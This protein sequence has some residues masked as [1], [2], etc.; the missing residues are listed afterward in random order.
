MSISKRILLSV[1]FLLCATAAYAATHYVSPTGTAEWA[2]STDIAQPSAWSTAMANAVAGDIVYFRGGTYDPGT[3]HVPDYEY[4]SMNP[5]N[6][7]TAGNTITF[8]AYP[9][10]TPTITGNNSGTAFGAG[11][12]DYIVW[13]GFTAT[14]ASSASVL[15]TA[16]VW[17]ST[18]SII[19]NSTFTGVANNGSNNFGSVRFEKSTDCQEPG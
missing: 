14:G 4:P 10:E 1:A 3:D 15:F 12:R 13:D 11:H 9:G 17:Y 5:T 8:I 16:H 18:G 19:R 7:G 2:A 6:S